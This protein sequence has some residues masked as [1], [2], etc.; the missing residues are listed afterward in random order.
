[1]RKWTWRLTVAPQ[2]SQPHEEK[3][4]INHLISHESEAASALPRPVSHSWRSLM[5][6]LLGALI[7]G[8]WTLEVW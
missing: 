5:G 3:L 1:M 8:Q 6:A 4:N 7:L 2:S